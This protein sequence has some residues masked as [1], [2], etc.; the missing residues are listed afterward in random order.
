MDMDIFSFIGY[1]CFMRSKELLRTQDMV[2]SS[3]QH[4]NNTEA[5]K[6]HLRVSKVANLEPW[7]G[8]AI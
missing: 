2:M 8:V 5:L 1:L 4:K 7:H 6:N 3:D